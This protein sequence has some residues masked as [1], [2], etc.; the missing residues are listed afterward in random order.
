MEQPLSRREAE[1]LFHASR[2]QKD[3]AIARLLGISTNTVHS[4][5]ERA[6][7]KIGVSGPNART[8]AVAECLR[9]GTFE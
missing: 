6:F 2:G 4:Y 8:L 1:V 5:V 3:A 9:A 7:Q